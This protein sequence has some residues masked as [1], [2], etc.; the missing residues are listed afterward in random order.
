MRSRAIYFSGCEQ[1]QGT[2]RSAGQSGDGRRKLGAWGLH[3]ESVFNFLD[4]YLS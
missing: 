4:N 3:F 2:R 1:N